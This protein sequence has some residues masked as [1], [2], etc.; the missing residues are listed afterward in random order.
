VAVKTDILAHWY[1]LL[2]DMQASG[3]EFYKSVEANVAK[4]QVPDA[5]ASRVE[6]KEG[7][8]L[9]AK[10]EYLRVTRG[11]LVFD[12]CAAPY[13]TGFFISWWMGRPIPKLN[14][15]ILLAIGV[16]LL[17]VLGALIQLVGFFLGTVIFLAAIP[18]A[19]WVLAYL[20]DEGLAD[21]EWMFGIPFLSLAYAKFFA[22]DTYYKMDTAQ[23]FQESIRA[24]VLEAVDGLTSAKGHRALTELERKP[25]LRGLQPR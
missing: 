22:P 24:A 23:M 2:G 17:F 10:R 3:L 5:K 14:P 12:I 18:T 13:G 6:F 4:R 1:T 9:T 8:V 11:K 7:G 21:D 19:M 25:I 15:L 20:A 16:G